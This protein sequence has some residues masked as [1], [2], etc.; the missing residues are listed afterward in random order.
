MSTHHTKPITIAEYVWIDAHGGICSKCK[1][2]QDKEIPYNIQS[3][4]DIST[5]P[6]WNFDGSST[7]QAPGEDSEV[8]LQPVAENH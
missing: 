1:T 3:Q 2:L 5:L 4:V 8:L 6:I 7:E